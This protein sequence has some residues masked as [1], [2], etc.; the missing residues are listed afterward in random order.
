M[1]CHWA[2]TQFE[3]I[4]FK[5]RQKLFGFLWSVTKYLNTM[6]CCHLFDELYLFFNRGCVFR[7]SCQLPWWPRCSFF[8]FQPNWNPS[9]AICVHQG[10]VVRKYLLRIKNFI[11]FDSYLF[12]II[13]DGFHKGYVIQKYVV[14]VK[15]YTKTL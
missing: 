11:N 1:L 7:D 2:Q 12:D 14:S 10:M 13:H 4:Y 3:R 5:I 9:P 8:A 6:S 15:N